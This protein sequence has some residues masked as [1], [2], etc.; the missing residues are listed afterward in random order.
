MRRVD[1]GAKIHGRGPLGVGE[2][3][4][5]ELERDR[6]G[7]RCA[8]D[9]QR[10]GNERRHSVNG[11]GSHRTSSNPARDREMPTSGH[12][13]SGWISPSVSIEKM[14]LVSPFTAPCFSH[15]LEMWCST[16]RCRSQ[17]MLCTAKS[18]LKS[19]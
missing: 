14:P 6:I 3:H 9:Q 10:E 7:L 15:S 13:Y 1:D 2:G 19:R 11:C 17:T 12:D 5:L 16:L 18:T 8:R 4:S